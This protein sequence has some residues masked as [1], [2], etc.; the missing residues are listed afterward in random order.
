MKLTTG[1]LHCKLHCNE[2]NITNTNTIKGYKGLENTIDS[3]YTLP[4][5]SK[6]HLE[7]STLCLVTSC[8][9]RQKDQV[10]GNKVL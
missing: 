2:C 3:C 8:P 1:K 6:E 10:K 5:Y 7:L 4:L 9:F